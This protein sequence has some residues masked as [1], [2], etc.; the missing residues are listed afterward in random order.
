MKLIR[1]PTMEQKDFAAVVVPTGILRSEQVVEMFLHF[2]DPGSSPC[3]FNTNHR[4][5]NF[6]TKTEISIFDNDT[7]NFSNI[8]SYRQADDYFEGITE[9]R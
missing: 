2:T 6:S 4:I 7:S 5:R 1:F 8:I 3:Q 9:I